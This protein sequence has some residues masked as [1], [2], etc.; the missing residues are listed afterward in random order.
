MGR[1]GY[2][3]VA[4]LAPLGHPDQKNSEEGWPAASDARIFPEKNFF[5]VRFEESKLFDNVS[6]SF[7]HFLQIL[8]QVV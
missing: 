7:T 4:T 6:T 8:Q 5:F 2:P 1:G 3:D